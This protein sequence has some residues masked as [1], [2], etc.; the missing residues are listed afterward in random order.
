MPAR[1]ALIRS[2][3]DSFSKALVR[4][5]HPTIDVGLARAQ[6]QE[7]RRHLKE[8]GHVIEVLPADEAHPDCVFVE[9]TAV[10]LG[11]TALITRPG[12]ESR[13]G[14]TAPV[15]QA[16]ADRFHIARIAPPGTL[17]GGD[18]LVMG[19]V[20][21][22]GRSSR[23]NTDGIDQLRALAHLQGSRVE[24]IDVQGVLHLKSAVLPVDD[25]TVVVTPGAVDETRLDG[26]RI[27]YE[28]DAERHRF[29]ALPLP[30]GKVMVTATAPA[31]SAAVASR[32]LE[33]IPVDVSQIQLADGGLT[34]M[35]ILFS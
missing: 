6:H 9:D 8:S 21:C 12:A 27:L 7:Y 13:R 30:G 5:G 31:T 20:V 35:S 17:D 10:I 22:V 28:H 24:A 16:L 29:S 15:E 32:G 26:L 33:V 23:T 1:T 14:E 3:P 34:C 2:V 4:Q 25:E 18:V 19:D 11:P